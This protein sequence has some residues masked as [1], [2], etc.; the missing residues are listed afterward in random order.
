MYLSDEL[1]PVL[2]PAPAG[3]N[4][5][6]LVL[7]VVGWTVPRARGDEPYIDDIRDWLIACS[8]RPRG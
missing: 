3:M 8:P 2:F 5:F 7:I 1:T 6:L 4:R